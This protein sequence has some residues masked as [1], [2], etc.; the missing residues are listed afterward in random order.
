MA[1]S[2][3]LNM[4]DSVQERER[5]NEKVESREGAKRKKNNVEMRDSR[6]SVVSPLKMPFFHF[7]WSSVW[8]FV[9]DKN[10]EALHSFNSFISM[11]A[12]GPPK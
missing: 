8:H 10:D 3:D 7:L 1:G 2:S 6:T 12:A 11:K 4:K 5:E 9:E